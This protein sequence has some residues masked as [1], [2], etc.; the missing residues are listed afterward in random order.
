M[1]AR[2]DLAKKIAIEAGN[3]Q[4]S[5]CGTQLN[6]AIKS[7]TV[8]I[9]TE[10]DFA[11]QSTIISQISSQFPED[12]ILAEEKYA[13][14][15]KSEWTWIIDPL[16]GTT[17]YSHGFPLYCVSIGLYKETK[18]FFGVIY[19][20]CMNELFEAERGEGAK[21]NGKPI[22]CSEVDQLDKAM[23]GTGFPYDINPMAED[24]VPQFK[25]FLME[26]QAVRRIGSAAIAL[27][28]IACGRLDG[29]W[30]MK[31]RPWDMAAGALMINEAG[32]LLTGYDNQ[33]FDLFNRKV[34]AS[35]GRIHHQMIEVLR[36]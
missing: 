9:V 7:S 26:A 25:N 19:A 2:Y 18:G 17:N 4:Q 36:R 10:I 3:L 28:Y 34:V 21:L 14:D 31:L 6:T 8:D 29:L 35:N 1:K 13:R 11:V 32:G 15:T 33:P 5:F 22:L 27:A 23:L 24:N 30:E 12:G 20:P 16:D